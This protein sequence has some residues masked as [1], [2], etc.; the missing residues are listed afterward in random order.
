MNKLLLLFISFSLIQTSCKKQDLTPSWLIID[1][2]E[3]ET[4]EPIQGPNSHNI[5]DAWVYMD[6]EPLGVF[7][8]PAKIPVLAEGE[9]EFIIYAG[10]MQNGI[11]AT[12]IKYP[13]YNR[14]D[15][16]VNLIK[17]QKTQIYPS[18]TYK[19][20]VQ[21]ELKEDFEDI[22]IDFQK[23]STSNTDM[24]IIS[25]T[26]YPDIVKYGTNCGLIELNSIDSL[27]KGITST[28]MNLPRNEDVYLEIDYMNTN[29]IAMGVIAENS[30]GSQEHTPLVLMNAQDIETLKWKKIYIDL[31]EDVSFE[32]NATSYEIYLI[33]I[34]DSDL[35][36][37]TIYIDNIKVVRF[38]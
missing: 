9:H 30:S 10:V 36:N 28:N 8:L 23:E 35:T 32:V 29:S 34:L 15:A 4:N 17:D 1:S 13:F 37:G 2:I 11:S 18:V 5:V 16:T 7:S 3:L 31:R 21:F 33:S 12:R 19:E 20:N 27:Y 25:Y 38:E 22:G 24:S 14:F 6:N 26:Q